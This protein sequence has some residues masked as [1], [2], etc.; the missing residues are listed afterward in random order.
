MSAKNHESKNAAKPRQ[1]RST[2]RW[3]KVVNMA[4][5]LLLFLL[6]TPWMR[7]QSALDGFAPNANG[8]VWVV[9]VQPDGKILIG[10]DFSTIAPNG[11]TPV[12]RNGIARLNPD[13]TLD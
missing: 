4:A 3:R 9:A 5:R 1:H 6:V 8:N 2:T 13:G 7:A 12:T 10:G 11:G